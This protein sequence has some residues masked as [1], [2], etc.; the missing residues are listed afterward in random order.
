MIGFKKIFK[1]ITAVS[2][3]LALLLSAFPTVVY[4]EDLTDGYYTYTVNE[5]GT[6]V[7]VTD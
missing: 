3:S 2:L 7:T 4:A 1:R 6:S 5:D